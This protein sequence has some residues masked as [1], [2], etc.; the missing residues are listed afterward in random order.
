MIFAEFNTLSMVYEDR[1][2]NFT[3]PEFRSKVL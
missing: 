2:D 1:S 3:V